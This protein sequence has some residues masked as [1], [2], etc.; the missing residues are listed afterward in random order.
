MKS[1]QEIDVPHIIFTINGEIVDE[2]YPVAGV[3]MEDGTEVE[4]NV[5]MGLL[6][7]K[8][9]LNKANSSYP[10]ILKKE[11]QDTLRCRKEN[12]CKELGKEMS[13]KVMAVFSGPF[14]VDILLNS[15]GGN[16]LVAERIKG[17][18][19]ALKVENNGLQINGYVTD[20]AGSAAANI[21]EKTNHRIA[22]PYSEFVW[23]WGSMG[24]D[25][26]KIDDE[27]REELEMEL[28]GLT[29]EDVGMTEPDMV[30]A[31]RARLRDSLVWLALEAKPR[32]R[33]RLRVNI[34]EQLARGTFDSEVRFSGAELHNYGVVHHL[35]AARSDMARYFR[36]TLPNSHKSLGKWLNPNTVVGKTKN[37][38]LPKKS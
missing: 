15:P 19:D 34:K 17:A 33:S 25:L 37:Y 36:S 13:D 26:S 3:L 2:N 31:V 23:H 1:P 8:L 32:R 28:D 21:F 11:L 38:F 27:A 14:Q 30:N 16:D 6:T 20:E 18:I 24:W 29:F 5:M 4:S 7:S 9:R 22:L 10:E 35:A 12:L